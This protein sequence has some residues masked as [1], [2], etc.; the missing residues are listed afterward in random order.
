MKPPGER[1]K[2][3]LSGWLSGRVDAHGYAPVERFGEAPE[4]HHPGAICK[5]A[6]TVIVY[7]K[8]IPR[9]V[10]TSPSYD[11]HLLQ[12][13]YH[14]AYQLLDQIGLE[15]A[16]LIE[17]EGYSAVGLPAYAPMIFHGLEPWGLISLKH[18]AH[19]AGLGSFG[20]NEIIHNPKFG[21][22]LRF[23]GVITNAPLPGDAILE[24]EACPPKCNACIEACPCGALESGSFRKIV[25]MGYSIKHGLYRPLLSDDYGLQNIEMIINT[26]GYNYW[27]ACDECT[28]VCP[29]NRKNTS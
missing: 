22:M 3:T 2:D 15:L 17:S 23:A 20:R 19:L 1:L 26:S 4:D 16:N 27:I 6:S 25:C 14:T 7:A 24:E 18:A 9:A 13:T 29:N 28:K 21:S 11:L 10:L 5:D 12:R 8:A